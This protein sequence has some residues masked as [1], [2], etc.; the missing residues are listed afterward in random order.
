MDSLTH[1]NQGAASKVGVK[2]RTAILLN[3]AAEPF[4]H[5]GELSVHAVGLSN[6]DDGSFIRVDKSSLQ[7]RPLLP[8]GKP[9]LRH[10]QA[11]HVLNDPEVGNFSDEDIVNCRR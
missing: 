6:C 4:H 8:A 11:V 2:L 5:A 7:P 1:Q 3:C 10:Y 9:G